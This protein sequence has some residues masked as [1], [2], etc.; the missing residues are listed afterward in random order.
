MRF[1][2]LLYLAL[3]VLSVAQSVNTT[4]TTTTTSA[5]PSA[6]PD[7]EAICESQASGYADDCPQCLYR[8]IGSAYVEQ[9]YYSTFFTVNGIQAQCEARGGWN[10]KQTALDSVCSG[11]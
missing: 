7:Y 5:A 2:S 3:P 4:L 9:C 1:T 8:C 6:T 11:S 10:C